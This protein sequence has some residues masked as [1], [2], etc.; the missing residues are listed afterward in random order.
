[1]IPSGIVWF[2][3]GDTTVRL[4]IN[5]I[6][7]VDIE[8]EELFT[9][10]LSD[11]PA[12]SDKDSIAV[13]K[14]KSS[15]EVTI[16]DDDQR[17]VKYSFYGSAASGSEKIK[18]DTIKVELDTT[19]DRDIELTYAYDTASSAKDSDFTFASTN[20]TLKFKA[21]TKEAYFIILITNDTKQEK[22]EV[23]TFKLESADPAVI[24]GKFTTFDYTITDDDALTKVGVM[25]QPT[26][27]SLPEGATPSIGVV[28]TGALKNDITVTIRAR[29][30]SPARAGTDY[31]I[32]SN[33][34]VVKASTTSQSIGLKLIRDNS[35]EFGEWVE[36]E[37]FSISDTVNA[38]ISPTLKNMRVNI[39][40][41]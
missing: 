8:D 3:P 28:L 30:S 12:L 41:N 35:P 4:P 16:R 33:V 36:F 32:T 27:I 6:N 31:T 37:I 24:A 5:I 23:I 14:S 21:G 34:I 38:E 11:L 9:I 19:L 25:L 29:E 1:M 7:D 18:S 40:D 15:I 39:T 2:A 20:H 26:T 22:D 13:N 10:D 17:T